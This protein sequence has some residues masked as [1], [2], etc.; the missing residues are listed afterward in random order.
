M[1]LYDWWPLLRQ[2]RRFAAIARMPVEI[3]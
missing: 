3:R 2:Q 1:F